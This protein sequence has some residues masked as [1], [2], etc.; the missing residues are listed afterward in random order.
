[1]E[2]FCGF[3]SIAQYAKGQCVQQRAGVVIELSK[4]L[5]VAFDNACEQS[6]V[7]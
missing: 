6:R 5:L 3:I 4:R 2:E 1:L 7:D